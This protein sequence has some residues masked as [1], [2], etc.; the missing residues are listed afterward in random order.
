MHDPDPAQFPPAWRA[1][2][3]QAAEALRLLALDEAVKERFLRDPELN[4]L[5]GRVAARYIAGRTIDDALPA[6]ERIRQRGHHVS[7]EYMGESCRDG[8]QA[9]AETGVFLALI[10]ALDAARMPGTICFDLSHVGSLVSPELGYENAR[11]IAIAAGRGGREVMIS[12]EGAE[13]ADAIYAIYAR[14]QHEAGLSHV[15]ITVPAKL[16]RTAEDLPRLLE[17]PGRIRLVKGAF[18]EPDSVALRRDDPLL[19]ER[20]RAY[21]GR[22]IDSGHLCSIATHDRAIQQD[23]AAHLQRSGGSGGRQVE[24]ESL[25]GLGTEQIDELQRRGFRTR[26]YAVFGEEYF[27]YVLNRIAEEPSRLFQAVSD[28]LAPQAG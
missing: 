25:M 15:G 7:V 27:L 14:L 23:L 13:R 2:S 3:R 5:A 4:R 8:A 11:R 28:L 16:H 1:A 20:Y 12:M 9:D 18:A 22:L 19:G 10:D 26:E 6:L 17:L 21:A 24:F